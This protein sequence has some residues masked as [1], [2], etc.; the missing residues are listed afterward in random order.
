MSIS[1]TSSPNS[2]GFVTPSEEIIASP[3]Q[4]TSLNT[5][6]YNGKRYKVSVI[7][8]DET[9]KVVEGPKDIDV[10]KVHRLTKE[11][12]NTIPSIESPS[13]ITIDQ[14]YVRIEETKIPHEVKTKAAWEKLYI[15]LTTPK[16]VSDVSGPRATIVLEAVD[17]LTLAE[18]LKAIQT[19]FKDS[20]TDPMH[21][22][23]TFYACNDINSEVAQDL[24]KAINQPVLYK[25]KAG[26]DRE[27]AKE[28]LKEY[29]KDI[30]HEGV[31]VTDKEFLQV[32]DC[33]F[34]SNKLLTKKDWQILKIAF[35]SN[36]FDAK[37]D[38]EKMQEAHRFIEKYIAT[39]QDPKQSHAPWLEELNAKFSQPAE[40]EPVEGKAEEKTPDELLK[41]F[42]GK[43]STNE[44]ATTALIKEYF[45]KKCLSPTFKALLNTVDTTFRL[46]QELDYLKMHTN[47]DSIFEEGKTTY[48]DEELQCFLFH[49]KNELENETQ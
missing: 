26:F 9:G 19:A 20:N 12:L 25:G 47:I 16:E 18:K 15:A 33:A 32:I 22:L 40:A 2:S 17:E 13:T 30:D 4:G 38:Q 37:D 28:L 35:K 29:F 44:A 23:Y 42:Y 24:S 46:E 45:E 6:E 27:L 5:L 1:S 36:I 21:E 10:E 48:T 3:T 14:D 11:L 31:K 34:H 43:Y 41:D 39:E 49:I 8:T 7:Y